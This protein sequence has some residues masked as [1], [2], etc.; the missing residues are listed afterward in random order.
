ML[1]NDGILPLCKNKKVSIIGPLGDNNNDILGPWSL[2]K[3]PDTTVTIKQG[4]INAGYK[5]EYAKG[6]EIDSSSAE[7]LSEAV[8]VANSSDVIL[9]ALGEAENMS[10]EAKSRSSLHLPKA[11][12]ELFN[13]LAK[14][15][16]EE[17]GSSFT[18]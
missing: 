6:C 15:D 3:I 7:L 12:L 2:D 5:V 9:L 17:E 11:Q 14:T 16:I 10:G 13:E 8:K 4:F 1:E 18:K